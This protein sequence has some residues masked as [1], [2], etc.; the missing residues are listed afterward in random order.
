MVSVGMSWTPGEFSHSVMSVISKFNNDIFY[1][2]QIFYSLI[3]VEIPLFGRWFSLLH[4]LDYLVNLSP[5]Q[6]NVDSFLNLFE[7]F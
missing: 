4:L 3:R 5:L 7:A 2:H 1:K 6:D